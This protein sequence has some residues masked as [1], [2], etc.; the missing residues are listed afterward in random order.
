V[1]SRIIV[2]YDKNELFDALHKLGP[3]HGFTGLGQR[4]VEQMLL[5]QTGFID[6][7]GLA[8]YGITKVEREEEN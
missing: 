8:L 3:T 5:N 4:L 2:E 1:K 6:A 7:V